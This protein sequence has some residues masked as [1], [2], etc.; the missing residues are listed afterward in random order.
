MQTLVLPIMD[1]LGWPA[2]NIQRLR[3][4]YRIG[5]RARVDFA[6]I[7]DDNPVALVEAKAFGN[8]LGVEEFHQLRDYCRQLPVP[9]AAL[10]SGDC[11][12]WY[13]PLLEDDHVVSL[14]EHQFC[15]LLKDTPSYIPKMLE[16]AYDE[17]ERHWSAPKAVPTPPLGARGKRISISVERLTGPPEDDDLPIPTGN[18]IILRPSQELPEQHR[19]FDNIKEAQIFLDVW[20]AQTP[21]PK[22]I[23]HTI[24]L[25][26]ETSRHSIRLPNS[27]GNSQLADSAGKVATGR[28]STAFGPAV[29]LPNPLSSSTR[30]IEQRFRSAQTLVQRD[31]Y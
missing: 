21:A 2:S 30:R 7:R 18:M 27:R 5:E 12:W 11:W 16:F 17:W 9:A 28:L 23:G 10:T 3:R 19:E 24:V 25:N 1:A 14:K 8:P 29:S 31:V 4:E 26:G 22:E 13:V 6:L 20:Q 15:N